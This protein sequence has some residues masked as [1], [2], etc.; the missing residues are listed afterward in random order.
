MSKI[1]EAH[2]KSELAKDTVKV[3]KDTQIERVIKKHRAKKANKSINIDMA[4]FD[5]LDDF[6]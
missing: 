2:T 4:D 3:S 1:S 6:N 5:F